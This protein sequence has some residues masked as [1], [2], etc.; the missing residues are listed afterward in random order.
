M[1]TGLLVTLVTATRSA[2]LTFL[3]SCGTVPSSVK[4]LPCLPCGNPCFPASLPYRSS[5]PLLLL[6]LT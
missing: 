3:E 6:E 2:L 1:V 5:L 4:P